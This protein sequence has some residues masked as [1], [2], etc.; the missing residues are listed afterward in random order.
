MNIFIDTNILISSLYKPSGITYELMSKLSEIHQLFIS[1]ISITEIFKHQ[2]RILKSTKIDPVDFEKL[3][4]NDNDK[5]S[6]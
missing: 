2:E 3:K 6:K 5:H 1:D 4:S